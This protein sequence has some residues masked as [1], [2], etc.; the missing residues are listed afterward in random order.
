MEEIDDPVEMCRMWTEH[1][2]PIISPASLTIISVKKIKHMIRRFSLETEEN[3]KLLLRIGL[4]NLFDIPGQ[5]VSEFLE[6]LL[7]SIQVI[8][9]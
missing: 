8:V 3:S 5:F 1:A 7:Q 4:K 2:A 6:T 9:K